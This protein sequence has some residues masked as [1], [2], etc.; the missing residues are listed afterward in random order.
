MATD[1]DAPRVVPEDEPPDA[2]LSAL[3]AERTKPGRAGTLGEE[4]D[5]DG[6]TVPPGWDLSGE[7]LTIQVIPAGADEFTC[8]ACFLVAHRSQRDAS[9]CCRDCG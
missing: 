4:P 7:S 6:G 8:P 9:G 2:T 1:Y 3:T 5:A